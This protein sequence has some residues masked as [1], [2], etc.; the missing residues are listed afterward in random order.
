MHINIILCCTE[1]H[2]KCLLMN[3]SAGE[4]AIIATGAMG[5]NVKPGASDK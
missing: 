3:S 5:G 4:L 1:N 2:P